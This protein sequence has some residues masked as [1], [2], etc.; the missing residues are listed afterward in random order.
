[1][2]ITA[3]CDNKAKLHGLLQKGLQGFSNPKTDIAD[4]YCQENLQIQPYL[5]PSHLLVGLVALASKNQHI[6][7][8]TLGCKNN[9][10]FQVLNHAS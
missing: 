10:N 7:F 2:T 9:D 1:M 8:D 6:A 4:N 5:V 3:V